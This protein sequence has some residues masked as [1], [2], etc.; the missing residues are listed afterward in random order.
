M[1][2]QNFL[3][4][5]LMMVFLMGFSHHTLS[6]S[7]DQHYIEKL[8]QIKVVKGNGGNDLYALIRESAQHLSV[9]WNEKLAIEI[10]RVFNELSNVNE[11]YFLVELLAPAVEKHKDK[12]KKILFKNLSKKNRVLYEK[13][14]EMV[15]KEEREGNG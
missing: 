14:V 3:K 10:S 4:F 7:L 11:N 8:Q 13:N 15:R 9:N 1:K 2:T 5:I 12:F 6:S